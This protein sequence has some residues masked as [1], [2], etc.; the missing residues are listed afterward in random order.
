MK[1]ELLSNCLLKLPFLVKFCHVLTSIILFCGS[2]GDLTNNTKINIECPCQ[3]EGDVKLLVKTVIFGRILCHFLKKK[4][5]WSN[6][7]LFLQVSRRFEQKYEKFCFLVKP[8]S[9]SNFYI[10]SIF[11]FHRRF[12]RY[13]GDSCGIIR[14]V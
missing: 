6:L 12:R 10:M 2:H 3:T 11:N 14:K 5:L 9:P 13:H 7:E 1:R 8:S 4:P